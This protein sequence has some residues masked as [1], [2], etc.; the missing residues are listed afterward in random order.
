MLWHSKRAQNTKLFTIAI[1]I[2]AWCSTRLKRRDGHCPDDEVSWV[3]GKLDGRWYF[4]I[5]EIIYTVQTILKLSGHPVDF[6][7]S[8]ATSLRGGK[9]S[10]LDFHVKGSSV[11]VLI[12]VALANGHPNVHINSFSTL[13]L[14]TLGRHTP[15]R[16]LHPSKLISRLVTSGGWL[17]I[18]CLRRGYFPNKSNLQLFS[19]PPCLVRWL[20]S[21]PK[22]VTIIMTIILESFLILAPR[23][24]FSPSHT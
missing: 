22:L 18:F 17:F 9:F 12:Y 5:Y 15:G 23:S 19:S 1:I 11:K 13:Y 6:E 7:W 21:S 10:L 14:I 8:S 24:R 20:I 16:L 4:L 3:V 2:T